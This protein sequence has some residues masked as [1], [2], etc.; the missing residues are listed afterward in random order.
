MGIERVEVRARITIGALSIETP[1]VQSFNVR[2]QRGQISSFDATLKVSHDEVNSTITGD[3]IKIYAGSLQGGIDLIFTGIVR[4]AKISPCFDD[5][6][7]VILSIGGTDVLSLLSGK[8]YT[9]RCRSSRTTWAA[10]TGLARPGLKSEKFAF[11]NEPRIELD[12]GELNREKN[13][14]NYGNPNPVTGI[15]PSVSPKSNNQDAVPITVEI[16]T[17]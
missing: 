6:K 14:V 1:F 15:T 9:R 7:Y 4:T 8:K 5:P 3:N 13:V 11:Q 10:I 2:K 17:E 16:T 12:S